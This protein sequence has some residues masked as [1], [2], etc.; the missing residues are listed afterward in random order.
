[1]KWNIFFTVSLLRL[2]LGSY[3]SY[4]G[5]SPEAISTSQGVELRTTVD[6]L[7]A[8]SF[9]SVPDAVSVHEISENRKNSGYT[10]PW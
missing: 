8:V 7:M 9:S 6:I 1:M 10:Y 3:L 5:M 2:D 4:L